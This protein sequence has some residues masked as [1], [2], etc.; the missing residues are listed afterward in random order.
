[1]KIQN[2]KLHTTYLKDY[3]APDFWVDGID[4]HF[5]LGEEKTIVRSMLNLRRNSNQGGHHRPLVLQGESLR[6]LSLQLND[7]LLSLHQFDLTDTSLTISNV[8]DIFTLEIITEVNPEKNTALSGLYRSKNMF[9]TQCEAQGFRRITYY[10]D[11][12]DVMAPFTTTI[13]ADKSRYPILLSNGNK[14]EEGQLSDNRHWVKWQDPFKKPC[15]LFALVAGDLAK[16]ADTFTTMSGRNVALEI[17]VEPENTDKC[18]HA[19]RSLKE[20]MRWDEQKYG[21]EYDLDIYMI[22][23][24]DDFNMGAMENKGLNL[25]NSKYILANEK[26]A[27]DTDFQNVEAVIGHEYFHN[28]T[29]NRITCRDWF[30]LSLK[31]GLTVFRE[32]QFSSDMGSPAVERIGDVRIIRTRQFA[33]DAG[34]MAHPVRPNSYIE[35]NNFYTT[36]IYNKGS[37]VIRM[38]HTILGESGFRKGMD[39]YFERHDG[40]AVTIEDF[41]TAHADANNIELKQFLRWYH[42][43][44][45]PLVTA[46]GEYQHQTK[47]FKLKITQS[48]PITP[49]KTEKKPFV[50]PIRIT[51]YDKDG[52]MIPLVS[53][54]QMHR[55][56]KDA[57][58]ILDKQTQEFVFEDVTTKPVPSL[59][60]NYSAPVK[61]DY[62][63]SQSDLL[64]LMT[65]DKDLFNRWDATQRLNSQVIKSLM[66]DYQDNKNLVISSELIEAY[67]ALLKEKVSDPAFVAQ[68]L[69]LPSFHY[70]AEELDKIDVDALIMARRTLLTHVSN[71]LQSEFAQ[72]Y[73]ASKRADDGMLTSLSIGHRELRNVCLAYLLRSGEDEFN[74]LAEQQYDN[75]RNMTDRMGALIALNNS[76]S[77]L[78]QTLFDNFYMKFKHEPLVVNKWLS[79][80]SCADLPNVLDNIQALL[81][82]EAFDIRNPN[83]VYALINTFSMANPERFHDHDGRGYQFLADRVIELNQLNPQVAARLL[84]ALTQFKRLEDKHGNLMK[85]A[86]VKIESSGNLSEDVYEIVT[87]SLSQDHA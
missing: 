60:G 24:V 72:V 6:L 41:V 42:Q 53:K 77:T 68:L 84:E 18:D 79:L 81:L 31:E 52:H 64:L 21:R 9:C 58:I 22:V 50:I 82:H 39:L 65:C 35:I 20:A 28:W 23:A 76:S 47:Q 25:F 87:K 67:R 12:P 74:K 37:E 3:L 62:P 46:C 49:D 13:I 7:Q 44:G 55:T 59:F 66:R 83:K 11:R 15:Y 26:T 86:I 19:M 10:L 40:K 17:F 32:Q 1:M 71:K 8:P 70:I 27:T 69:I 4:L 16:L 14:V 85:K 36:T 5:E 43:A 80:H 78:R 34:P 54:T 75:A 45:T 29:G 56:G 63:Y 57:V 2:S 33:E 30:Q 61:L 51:L 38:L 48:C 73:Y